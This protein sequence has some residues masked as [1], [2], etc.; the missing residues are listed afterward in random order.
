M[1]TKPNKKVD[2]HLDTPG[3]GPCKNEKKKTKQ[4]KTITTKTQRKVTCNEKT[5]DP[6]KEMVCPTPPLVTSTQISQCV[7]VFLSQRLKVESCF[8]S[9]QLKAGNK[10]TSVAS[11]QDP[12]ISTSLPILDLV[13]V[14]KPGVVEY[15]MVSQGTSDEVSIMPCSLKDNLGY[16]HTK[17]DKFENGIL[18]PITDEAFSVHTSI[19]KLFHHPTEIQII[20]R[21]TYTH[22]TNCC[23]VSIY[24]QFCFHCLSH[25][26]QQTYNLR[27]KCWH[28]SRY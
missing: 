16:V 13:D 20:T 2:V 7:V 23:H 11:F 8:V 19:F 28:T 3:T 4:N 10:T 21:N 24:K 1:I 17:V 18:V 9:F 12:S 14:I 15:D 6:Q 26:H 22:I 25:P 5:V 27:Q